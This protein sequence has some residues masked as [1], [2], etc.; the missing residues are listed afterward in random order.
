M[1]LVK[2]LLAKLDLWSKESKKFCA[3]SCLTKYGT[4][5]IMGQQL[6]FLSELKNLIVGE[7]KIK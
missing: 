4:F 6:N 5:C 1:K 2:L 7:K 3:W